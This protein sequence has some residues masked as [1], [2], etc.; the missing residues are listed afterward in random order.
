VSIATVGK[1]VTDV[2]QNLIRSP[3][4]RTPLRAQLWDLHQNCWTA[5]PLATVHM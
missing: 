4:L 3:R 1:T 2:A 5:G